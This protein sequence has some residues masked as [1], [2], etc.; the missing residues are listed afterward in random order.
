MDCSWPEY[1]KA[2]GTIGIGLIAAYIAFLAHQTN[3]N[4]LRFDLFEKR[5]ALYNSL[6]ESWSAVLANRQHS[7]EFTDNVKI[8]RE[9]YFLFDKK[10]H[11]EISAFN[12]SLLEYNLEDIRLEQMNRQYREQGI[13]RP[14]RIPL[15]DKVFEMRKA[16]VHDIEKLEKAV[17]P[18]LQF[19]IKNT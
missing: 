2:F 7:I 3:R 17:R 16:V 14:E 12:K 13:D 15:I 4:K 11:R 10:T 19:G 8:H 5:F 6:Y 9:A 1:V 18:Y